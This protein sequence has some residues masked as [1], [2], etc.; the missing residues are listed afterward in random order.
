VRIALT[1]IERFPRSGRRVRDSRDDGLRVLLV[2]QHR[3]F[4]RVCDDEVCVLLFRHVRRDPDAS[5]LALLD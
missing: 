2:G 1:T 4:Y 3:L 5:D